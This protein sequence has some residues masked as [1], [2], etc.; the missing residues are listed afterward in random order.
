MHFEF[1]RAKISRCNAHVYQK[2]R[3]WGSASPHFWCALSYWFRLNIYASVVA[4]LFLIGWEI[5]D[6]S[7]SLKEHPNPT[8]KFRGRFHSRIRC[9]REFLHMSQRF[10]LLP[11]S[12]RSTMGFW[13]M[14]LFP[15]PFPLSVRMPNH[16]VLVWQSP[17]FMRVFSL[18]QMMMISIY[19]SFDRSSS[20]IS[21]I[22][23]SDPNG[24]T[25]PAMQ[26]FEKD[27]S[28]L[29]WMELI[30]SAGFWFIWAWRK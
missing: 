27:N 8:S 5:F 21:C 19:Q 13:P 30:P 22:P 7:V 6:L 25:W 18:S 24:A 28:K 11:W 1:L 20:K 26:K 16:W 23:H 3:P 4:T 12:I 9:C 2:L 17:I 15:C 29:K 10:R 14:S